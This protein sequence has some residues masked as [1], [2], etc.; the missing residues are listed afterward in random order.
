MDRD[1]DRS[2]RVARKH[3]DMVTADDPVCR[4]AGARQSSNDAAAVHGRQLSVGHAQAATVTLRISGIAS[5]GM[6]RP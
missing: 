1:G 6:G 2:N 3:H 5:G 4:E